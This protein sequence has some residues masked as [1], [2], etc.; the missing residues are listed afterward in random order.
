MIGDTVNALW[1]LVDFG[2]GW[3]TDIPHVVYFISEFDGTESIDYDLFWEILLKIK[4]ALESSI[5]LPQLST[6]T[7][8]DVM[9]DIRI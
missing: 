4:I 2:V 7:I 5:W 9:N 8:F 1:N 3:V 6:Q